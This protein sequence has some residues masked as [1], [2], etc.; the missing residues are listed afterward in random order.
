MH[1]DQA[2]YRPEIHQEHLRAPSD[3]NLQVL[4]QMIWATAWL[5]LLSSTW[6]SKKDKTRSRAT[7]LESMIWAEDVTTYINLINA[8]AQS[9]NMIMVA[10]LFKLLLIVQR[11]STDM[12]NVIW[13]RMFL[14]CFAF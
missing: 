10:H 7:N 11:T 12:A 2:T 9:S 4:L 1:G 5:A 13:L 14:L 3:Y 8:A 6:Q